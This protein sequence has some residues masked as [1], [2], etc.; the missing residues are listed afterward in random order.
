MLRAKILPGRINNIASHSY[1]LCH[2]QK[3]LQFPKAFHIVEQIVQQGSYYQQEPS[4]VE[5]GKV[6]V[7]G[8][9]II[10]PDVNRVAFF[11]RNDIFRQKIEQDIN[12]PAPY[13]FQMEY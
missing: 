12:Y 7:E 6:L 3:S 8:D 4:A 1:K 11:D 9:Q 10:Q 5:Y 2:D 13:Q